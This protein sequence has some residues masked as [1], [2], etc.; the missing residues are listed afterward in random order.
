[1]VARFEV[2]PQPRHIKK[3][4]LG[5][6]EVFEVQLNPLAAVNMYLIRSFMQLE[7]ASIKGNPR[8]NYLVNHLEPLQ[9]TAARFTVLNYSR[10]RSAKGI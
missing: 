2:E 7:G 10:C 4:K 5:N 6:I 8:R 1:M 9:N 3:R